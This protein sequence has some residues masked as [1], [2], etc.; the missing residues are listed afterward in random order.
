MKLYLLRHGEAEPYRADDASRVLTAAGRAA[1]LARNEALVPVTRVYCSPYVRARQ[2]AELV[3]A[4]LGRKPEVQPLLTPEQ[5]VEAVMDWL[6]TLADGDLC[7]IGHN[8]LLSA[9]ANRLLGEYSAVS[10]ATAGLASLESE[11]WYPGSAHLL[12]QR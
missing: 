1:I 2:S 11:A 3:Q 7:L 9:L 8:P 6:N 10:L 12:F 4:T 5:P